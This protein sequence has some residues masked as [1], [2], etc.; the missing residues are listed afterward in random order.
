MN[1]ETTVAALQALL[2]EAFKELTTEM[3]DS[4]LRIRV[5]DKRVRDFNATCHF[6][7][8]PKRTT[9]AYGGSTVLLNTRTRAAA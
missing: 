2:E 5:D 9:S 8:N 1:V 3:A 4:R 6:L 7:F